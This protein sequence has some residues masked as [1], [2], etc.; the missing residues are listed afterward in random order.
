VRIRNKVAHRYNFSIVVELS[1]VLQEEKQQP[2]TRGVK[3][4]LKGSALD[5]IMKP[6]KE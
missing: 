6:A 2:E 3:A 5:S 1:D 4:T